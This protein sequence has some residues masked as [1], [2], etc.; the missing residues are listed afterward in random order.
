MFVKKQFCERLCQVN[1]PLYNVTLISPR[2][3]MFTGGGGAANT[4]VHNGFEIFEL[5]HNGYQCCA[6]SLIRHHTN[7]LACMNAAAT[8][9]DSVVQKTIIAVGQNENCQTY[10]LKLVQENQAELCQ[11]DDEVFVYDSPKSIGAVRRMHS[12]NSLES[13]KKRSIEEG[14]N[15]VNG[16]RWIFKVTPLISVQT[17]HHVPE[18]HQN[19]VKISPL[20]ENL[21]V[22]G[23]DD[24]IIKLWSF[25]ELNLI[26]N[27]EEHD[28]EIDDIAFSPDQSKIISISKDRRA[29]VW[30]AK[31]LKKYAEM[32]WTPPLNQ[33]YA[34]KRVKCGKIDN[35]PKKYKIYTIVNPV[36]SN[37]SPA[38]V[39]KWDPKYFT[40]EQ[41][42][43]S[44]GNLSALDVSDN[45]NFVA[46]G[47]MCDG[48]VKIYIA[49]DMKLIKRVDNCHNIFI[50]GV[51]FLPTTEEAEA[52]RGMSV[53]SVMSI[54]VDHQVCIHHIPR[55]PKSTMTFSY[56][57]IFCVLLVFF[58][59][60]SYF[61]I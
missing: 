41:S 7:N 30:D 2:H 56:V 61:E 10:E 11:N 49:C 5:D 14:E 16:Q 4:G 39:Q 26:K 15:I 36:S 12:K 21:M 37:K 38:Y 52:I 53:C 42:V 13:V 51:K 33:K 8:N 35:D 17:D 31:R 27:F 29:L 18:A 57:A 58:F 60:F 28:K 59:T 43:S 40:M 54:S 32:T 3:V 44:K 23:G 55:V 22:T 48:I 9:F 25:P 20:S 6:D 34:Y 24:G 1:F 47:S 45:G 50:T 46:T 19:V